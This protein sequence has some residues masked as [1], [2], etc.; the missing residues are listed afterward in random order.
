SRGTIF[1]IYTTINMASSTMGQLAMSMT[2]TAGYIP[3]VIGAIAFICAV[4][5]TSLTS[6]PQ[7]RP[8]A[9]AK[10]DLPL[11]IK[12]SPVAAVAAFCCGM[13]NGSFG[14]LAPVYGY[15]QG[16]NASGIALLFAIAAI[17]GAVGQIPFGRLSD[18]IDRRQVMIG[19]ATAAAL[20]G[21]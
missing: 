12:T 17:S 8:L 11:L 2:G 1:S 18:K 9:S 7:P 14:T 5:P 15:E 6:S 4:L 21:L 20:V 19:L 16:L 13:A 10:L 3:F